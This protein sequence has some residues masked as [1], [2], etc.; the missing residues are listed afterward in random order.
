MVNSITDLLAGAQMEHDGIVKD[1]KLI[2]TCT[3]SMTNELGRLVQS[4]GKRIPTG[5]DNV[6]FITKDAVL[7]GKV[8]IYARVLCDILP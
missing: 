8:A 3:K 6:H 7:K 5:S 2:L 4:V 1:P